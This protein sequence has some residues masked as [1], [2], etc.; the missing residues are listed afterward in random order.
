[1]NQSRNTIGLGGQILFILCAV[2]IIDTLTAA[3]A[4]GPSVI[5]WWGITLLAFVLP[6]A[7]IA[8][9][10]GT[11]Y[12]ADGG[13]YDWVKRAFGDKMAAR[14]S[15]LYWI[16]VGL[17]M[18]AVYILFAG[19]ASELFDLELSLTAQV[20]LCIL[21]TW[22]TVW[23]C[24]VA[25]DI[26]VGISQLGALLK[27]VVI[28][29]LG[30][31]G[32]LY[33]QEHG[34]ANQLS[35]QSMLP[36]FEGGVGFLP[37]IIYNLLGLELVACLGRNLKDPVRSMPKAMLLAS[38]A[39]ALLYVFGTLGILV[40]LPVDEVSLVAGLTDAL[41][42]LFAD[43][44]YGQ[45]WV[46]GLGILGLLTLISNMVSWTMGSSRTAAEAA[47]AGE[48]P[49]VLGYRHPRLGTP[50]GANCLTGLVSTAVILCY[51]LLAS[52]NDELFWTVFAFSS[53]V[54]LLPYLLMFAAFLRLR[55]KDARH[56][57][58]FWLPSNRLLAWL[59][60]GS[61]LSFIL[62][63]LLLFIFPQLA[64]GIIDWQ[65]SGPL[66]LG[67]GVTLLLGEALIRRQ[68]GHAASLIRTSA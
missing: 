20:A 8:T 19:M 34:M 26:G 50:V 36:S 5:G 4:L 57:R 67:L 48:L 66:L 45:F 30:I 17:W 18:P 13:L 15:W 32:F 55:I 6:Y 68:A 53:C 39:I 63:A 61:S 46:L 59:L 51:G 1:M 27:V 58:P 40:A 22:L 9:E 28:L 35:W 11:A 44:P 47:Q 43:L 64:D 24:N 29:A 14:T 10:L 23:F 16:N 38:L 52:S 2:L 21:L 65:E 56:P 62:G 25:V 31:A 37:A 54:F 49:A 42:I 60:T 33:A 3:A 41:T 12:P 7:L